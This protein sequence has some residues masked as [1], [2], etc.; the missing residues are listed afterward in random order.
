MKLR[1]LIDTGSELTIISKRIY[2]SLKYKN[3]LKRS[4]VSLHSANGEAM[5]TLGNVNLGFKMAGLKFQ[6]D[7]LVVSDLSRNVIIGR[8][9]LVQNEARL[10]FDLMKMRIKNVYIPLER[11]TH[12]A[13]ITRLQRLQKLK[14]HTAY[15]LQ[16]KVSKHVPYFGEGVFQFQPALKGFVYN[17]PE[18]EISA[19]L[20]KMEGEHCFPVQVIN[21]SNKIMRLKRGQVLGNIE[22]ISEVNVM[23]NYQINN[24]QNRTQRTHVT[25]QQ[26]K[27]AIKT[28]EKIRTPVSELLLKNR[29]IFAFNDLDLKRTDL[30]EADVDTGSARPINLKPYRTP[31]MQRSVVSKT[32]DDLLEAGLIRRSDS[33]WNF[34][35]VL[36]DKKGD[37]PDQLPT[38]RMC[39]DFR[40]LNK[41]IL[42]KSQPIPLIDDILSELKGTTFFTTLDLRSG[43]HQI[44]LTEEGAKRCAFS[45]FK[46]KF[47]FAVLP[48]GLNTSSSIF[49]RCINKLLRGYEEFCIAYIDDILIHTKGSLEDHLRHVSLIFERIRKH[50]LRL[51]LA[52]C[53]WAMTELTYLGF[54]VNQ[55]GVSPC[56]DKVQ[57]I[58]L[59]QPPTTVR[60]VRGLLGM[61]GW[62]RRFIPEFSQTSEP[63]ISLTKKYA[64]FKWDDKCQSAFEQLKADLTV[65]PLLAYPD[66]NK[67]YIL[68]TD[69]SKNC[70]GSVLVQECEGEMWIPGIKDEKPIYFLSHKM[71]ES[72]IR[73]YSVT[74]KE[75][76]AIHYSLN[77]LH[78]YLHN[79]EFVIKTDHKP[80]E[81]LFTAFT[82]SRR[83]TAWA[84]NVNSYRCR[85]E[86]LPGTANICA[87]LLSRSS[88]RED[89]DAEQ[90]P[91]ISERA[92]EV[93]VLNTNDFNPTDY[94][95]LEPLSESEDEHVLPTL[96]NFDVSFEQNKDDDL[97][98][99]KNKLES[100]SADTKTYKSFMI[101]ENLLYYISQVDDDPVLRLYIPKHL[102]RH[103]ID[104]FHMSGGH[105][106]VDKTFRIIKEK[107][108][109]PHMYKEI[110]EA[111]RL[112]ETC[113]TTNLQQKKAP[114]QHTSIPPY[115]MAAL[116]LDLSGPH[117]KTLSGNLYIATFV[118]MYSGWLECFSLPDKS[119][120][121]VIEC[122]LDEVIP[123]HSV[124]LSICTDN[125]QEFRSKAFEDTLKK[126]NIH[127]MLTSVYAP[128]SNGTV[129]RSHRTLNLILSKLMRD[130]VDS[131]DLHLNHA[132]LAMRTTVSKTTLHS[133]FKLLYNRDAT[134]PL[135]NLLRPRR[136]TH[137]EDYHEITLQNM[138][139]QFMEVLRN[140]QNAKRKRNIY[141]NKNRT[142]TEF[143]IGDSVYLKNH[144]KST[145]LAKNWRTHFVITH[146][147]GPVSFVLR[148]Q[149]TGK[150]TK[151]HANSLRLAELQWKV[152]EPEGRALRQAQYV[153]PPLPIS[154][155]E[156]ESLSSSESSDNTIIYD[157]RDWK[158]RAVAKEKKIREDSGSEQDVPRF[159]LRKRLR[160]RPKDMGPPVN[161]S[162]E[163]DYESACS[164]KTISSTENQDHLQASADDGSNAGNDLNLNND[165]NMDEDEEMELN[166]LSV[167]TSKTK[168]VSKE[169]LRNVVRALAEII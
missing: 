143:N 115:P 89:K 150:T 1:S 71:S 85:L 165:E 153:V 97:V 163:S 66:P 59:L 151:A 107:Y 74:E 60:E 65:V 147:M 114:V 8:D 43:F 12:V 44:P 106:S 21:R 54:Q 99:I 34:P 69:A 37:S 75:L 127:H 26:F 57:A 118:C 104:Q 88:P 135:D 93:M 18:I 110:H 121:S 68:Y 20:I 87:D 136:K 82:N 11:D 122:L 86:Y 126:L 84:V 169:K 23:E 81:Y 94:I 156:S 149:L 56:Q 103:V 119:S 167:S 144:T 137:S 112:C 24:S 5:K 145:K 77:K 47:E 157:A 48:F 96:E 40:L 141:A 28:E 51:K 67:P 63:L 41:C 133:P 62:Y 101:Q 124:P 58:K 19:S 35:V 98:L 13:S 125:G 14:P 38:K 72:Q 50:S 61:V 129:E 3:P 161:N 111:I 100:G 166:E 130:Q 29:D 53:Q 148:N 76:F 52:K 138:H 31:I 55:H 80:L 134:L 95:A 92:L 146:K 6:H 17:Q 30:L 142:N 2:D 83:I 49:Q 9:F 109:W 91:D 45:C 159:E 46:G 155:D 117:S 73:S 140:T 139:R 132:L 113:I 128:S 22:R 164:S 70:I 160:K 152:P 123:R 105:F 168:V 102:K 78:F 33:P 36:V 108:F 90:I 42:P 4:N 15:L 79:A 154:A 10:Y 120:Q 64:R 39:I 25:E 162:S 27:E 131:W 16:A 158:T 7:F 116:Q 32:I